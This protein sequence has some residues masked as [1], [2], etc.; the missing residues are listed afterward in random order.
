MRTRGMD[1][2]ARG[3]GR[4]WNKRS[5]ESKR[6]AYSVLPKDGRGDETQVRD[7]S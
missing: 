2:L 1:R 5:S 3:A 4:R 6:K 7:F